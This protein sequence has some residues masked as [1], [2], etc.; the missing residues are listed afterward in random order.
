LSVGEIYLF[1]V[2]GYKEDGEALEQDKTLFVQI[3]PFEAD[4]VMKV[5][6][7]GGYTFRTDALKSIRAKCWVH[8]GRMCTYMYKPR[9]TERSAEERK[10]S[11]KIIPVA[12]AFIRD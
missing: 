12:K 6:S 11:M 1:A 2:V 3:R 8:A 4:G 9:G 7:C 5:D 10:L